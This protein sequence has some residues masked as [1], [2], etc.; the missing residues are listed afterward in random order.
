[1]TSTTFLQVPQSGQKL[2]IDAKNSQFWRFFLK[3]EACSQTVLPDKSILIGQKVDNA[4][5]GKLK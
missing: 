4:K 5:I 1:M 3:P 2:I